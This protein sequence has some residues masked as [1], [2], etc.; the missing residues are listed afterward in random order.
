MIFS[1]GMEFY[2]AAQK[3][4]F[5]WLSSIISVEK[6]IVS[7]IVALFKIKYLLKIILFAVS[8]Q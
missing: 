7:L 2:L 6:S 4:P 3:M 8:F 5:H 1:L